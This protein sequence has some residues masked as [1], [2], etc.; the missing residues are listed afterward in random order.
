MSHNLV[1]IFASDVT[2]GL[3][4]LTTAVTTVKV[5]WFVTS[6]LVTVVARRESKE[7]WG[8]I[9]SDVTSGVPSLPFFRGVA[10]EYFVGPSDDG[11]MDS[12][13]PLFYLTIINCHFLSVRLPH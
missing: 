11:H 4:Q 2:R 6:L 7:K 3:S 8:W 9:V 5:A 13:G 1:V 12:I 10:G